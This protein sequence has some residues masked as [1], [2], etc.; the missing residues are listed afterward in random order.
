MKGHPT[1]EVISVGEIARVY[2]RVL[3]NSRGK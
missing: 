3:R 2:R 1:H